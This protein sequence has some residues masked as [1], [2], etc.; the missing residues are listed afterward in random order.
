MVFTVQYCNVMKLLPILGSK[1]TLRDLL[2]F[3]RSCS[4][5]LWSSCASFSCT[6]P[7]T[8]HAV[9]LI[10]DEWSRLVSY[11]S[12]LLASKQQNWVVVLMHKFVCSDLS[13]RWTDVNLYLYHISLRKPLIFYA[14]TPLVFPW[15]DVWE[16]SAEIP[17]WWSTQWRVISME[18]LHL[19]LRCQFTGKPKWHR[20]GSAVFLRLV[21]Y[22]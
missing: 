7:K 13:T 18:F 6:A 1:L 12:I 15:N 4:L 11:F 8:K 20:K 3:L 5:F 14:M 21:S 17:Y 10:T 19:F 9:L 2:S 22:F 16:T